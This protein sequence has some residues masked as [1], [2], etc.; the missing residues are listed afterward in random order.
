MEQ[1]VRGSI[2]VGVDGSPQANRALVWAAEQAARGR[3]APEER[4]VRRGHAAGVMY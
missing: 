4:P 1:I 2:V 3:R